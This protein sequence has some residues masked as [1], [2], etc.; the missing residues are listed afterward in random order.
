MAAGILIFSQSTLICARR[1]NR[2]A[3]SHSFKV[4][5]ML[6]H[7]QPPHRPRKFRIRALASAATLALV[8]ALTA[9]S[10]YADVRDTD[11]I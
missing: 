2:T 3:G 7:R 5:T 9:P 4:E 6:K 10:A 11:I 1:R 8:E